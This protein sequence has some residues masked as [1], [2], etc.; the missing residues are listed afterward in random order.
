MSRF[1]F[2][3]ARGSRRALASHPAVAGFRPAAAAIAVAAA[4]GLQS[5]PVRAQPVGGQ[6]IAG[7][8]SFASNGSNLV[9][10][11][12]NAAGTSHSA[13]NW[14][15]F[16]VPAGSLTRFNQPSAVSTS[17]NRV[18]GPDPSS[19]FGTLSSNGRLVL[20]NPAGIAVGKGAVVDT[21][22]FTASTLAMSEADAIAGRQRFAGN[23]G[24]LQVDGTIVAR[25]GDVVLIA[26]TVQ[27]GAD[28]LVQSANGATLL[29]AG[30]KVE[31]TGR[32]LEGIRLEV[33]APEN[34]AVNLGTLQGDAVGIFA[35]TL[36]HSGLV[37]ARAV[38]TDGGK[39]LLRA[40]GDTL[41]SG[42]IEASAANGQGGS[43]D[44]LGQRVGLLAGAALDASG[45]AGGG[46]V[47]VGGDYQGLNPDVQNAK[48]TY[49]DAQAT[50]KADATQQGDGGR[51]IVWSD[52]A[53]RMHGQIS[54]RGGAQGGNGGFAEVSGKQYLEFTGRADLRAP[55]GAMG[56]LLLDP[57]DIEINATGPTDTANG[58]GGD[59]SGGPASSVV[60]DSD[61]SAQ[62]GLGNVQVT[63]ANGS[64]G[65]LGGQIT[66]QAGAT[67]NWSSGS[68]LSL[69]ANTGISLAGTISA[70]D[71]LG[72]ANGRL[73]LLTDTGS[74]SQT[75]G[76]AITVGGLYAG[77]GQY[78]ASLAADG[79]Q[80]TLMGPNNVVNT[81]AGYAYG[82]GAS[83]SFAR[84]SD[85]ANS[86]PL[87]IG[88]VDTAYGG[89]T[90][91]T[92]NDGI[93]PGLVS[94]SSNSGLEV[95]SSVAGSSIQL[96]A[97]A[98]NLN[99][100]SANVTATQGSLGLSATAGNVG[101]NGG[102]LQGAALSIE[103]TTGNVSASE[104]S[105][106][107]NSGLL[108]V[109]ANG[110]LSID[111]SGSMSG[112]TVNLK[113]TTGSIDLNGTSV[114]ANGGRLDIAASQSVNV[115]LA[116]SLSLSG[117]GGAT[118]GV[119]IAATTGDVNLAS[120]VYVYS[121]HSPIDVT[122]GGGILGNASFYTN[123]M[124][125][126][127]VH[128]TA[129]NGPISFNNINSSGS[130][131][132]FPG[133]E[134]RLIAKGDISGSSIQASGGYNSNGDGGQGAVVDVKSE[135]GNIN[136]NSIQADG[137]GTGSSSV[138]AGGAGG[139]VTLLATGTGG[140][141]TMGA[142]IYARGGSSSQR[143]G[144]AGGSVTVTAD[145]D[146]QMRYLYATAGSG[147]RSSVE[148]PAASG[149]AGGTVQLTSNNGNIALGQ[150]GPSVGVAGGA[151][152]AGGYGNS[153]ADG[154]LGGAITLSAPGGNVLVTNT[155]NADGGG[156]GSG[157]AGD[158]LQASNAITVTA[159]KTIT[160]SNLQFNGGNDNTS[161]GGAG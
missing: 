76:S 133:G 77:A 4:F 30:Q 38:T 115:G 89:G 98:G 81:L 95:N 116:G 65:P 24:A 34:K 21:A 57:N 150:S 103:S 122:A 109:T 61:L 88:T 107:A 39:V 15:S 155:L 49:V 10:T 139:A 5:A 3:F 145:S 12:Q 20:V 51:V 143:S 124:L 142:D 91:I 59:F 50:I 111:S 69:K 151:L 119:R 127:S 7:Q 97:A 132:G 71:S 22:G 55:Q 27:T 73:H 74:I 1:P 14:Q 46:Q 9:V 83:F 160:I 75:G 29:A 85:V 63:T 19:I 35:G 102:S 31:I 72:A 147:T 47:R 25:S 92:A 140:T 93:N 130:Y 125:E 108:D 13:I 56:T 99:V 153:L 52:E 80:V 117:N 114:Y 42:A 138:G 64:L 148:D 128:L 96:T 136:L 86:G 154:G 118:G 135:T 68:D 94:V 159:Q 54:A 67:V 44:V 123:G 161:L 58:S 90:G 6:A 84:K 82:P 152:V 101:I 8:A 131:S 105:L 158:A 121:Y 32:G 40:Q 149:G 112:T 113:A 87:T 18:L 79:G 144:G 17:I 70:T 2:R 60:K 137:G 106:I 23:G 11:T 126:G 62:L 104:S 156:S 36:K 129:S 53:T 43:I 26:P 28:A 41:V 110:N 66:L 48:R 134:V 37:Q 78:G 16:S 141:V 146:I 45:A 120:G 100:N 157:A 33:Q